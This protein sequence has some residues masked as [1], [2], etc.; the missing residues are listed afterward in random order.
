MKGGVSKLSVLNYDTN[1]LCVLHP[2]GLLS[3]PTW[4]M[5]GGAELKG[6]NE[7]FLKYYIMSLNIIIV[8][9]EDPVFVLVI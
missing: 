6:Q 5:R 8:E 4:D 2:F 3:T 1:P 9:I 7:C